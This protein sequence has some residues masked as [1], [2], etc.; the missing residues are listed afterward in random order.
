MNSAA[1]LLSLGAILLFG[2]LA[3]YIGKRTPLPRISLL[4]LVGIVAGEHGFGLLSPQLIQQFPLVTDVAL[5]LVGFLL[6]GQFHLKQFTSESRSILWISGAAAVVTTVIVTGALLL[7]NMP[8]PLAFILGCIAAATAPAPIVDVIL[9]TKADSRFSHLLLRVV[10]IDDVWAML[11]FSVGLASMHL[12]VNGGD[13]AGPLLEGAIEIGGG[14]LL[15]ALI[16]LPAAYLTGRLKPGQPTL[17]EALGLVLICGGIAI[18]LHLSFLLAVMVMG[19][20]IVNLAKHHDYPFHEIENIEWP[21]MM[22]FFVLAGASLD[23]NAIYGLGLTGLAYI[24]GRTIG[25]IVGAWLGGRICKTDTVVKNWIG[26][27]MLP[28][29][30]VPIGM[31]LIAANQFPEY[32]QLLLS[33]IIGA[34]VCFELLGPPLTRLAISRTRTF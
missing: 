5:L 34:T 22:F 21:V 8:A 32:R 10:A 1:I 3:D 31:A 6:G 15:G 2:L 27:A 18:W 11:L 25:K 33:V 9:Q 26:I 23:L 13:M 28:H 29:A 7:L 14:I 4:L 19:T 12:M 30:G 24:G 20:M 17:L 16:G